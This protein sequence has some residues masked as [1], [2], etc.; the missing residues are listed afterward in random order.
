[1]ASPFS[2]LPGQNRS[3]CTS[4]L[5][6]PRLPISLPFF[7][8]R[9]IGGDDADIVAF[10]VRSEQ[11]VN[12]CRFLTRKDQVAWKVL[13]A[14]ILFDNLIG[15]YRREDRLSREES[16]LEPHIHVIGP[17]DASL[18]NALLNKPQR[19]G[20]QGWRDRSFRLMAAERPVA[21]GPHST[22]SSQPDARRAHPLPSP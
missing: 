14:R 16:S 3:S 2:S 17:V 6:P 12:C 22:T 9:S 13:V 4:S 7:R 8:V 19:I 1:M 5:E 21:V 10:D 18:A 15:G 11:H 20:R